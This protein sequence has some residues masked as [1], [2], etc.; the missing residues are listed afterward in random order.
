MS[1][2]HVEESEFFRAAI[3]P[4]HEIRLTVIFN[5][6]NYLKRGAHGKQNLI[7]RQLG[8]RR[9]GIEAEIRGILVQYVA[10]RRQGNQAEIGSIVFEYL[11]MGWEGVETKIG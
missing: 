3:S 11:D 9:Q 8:M 1:D 5:N 7:A 2:N 4:H 6:S 10:V